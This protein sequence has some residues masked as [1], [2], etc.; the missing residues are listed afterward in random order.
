[1]V[2]LVLLLSIIA[3]AWIEPMTLSFNCNDECAKHVVVAVVEAVV[4]V[5]E[6]DC[7]RSTTNVRSLFFFFFDGAVS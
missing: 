3:N 4:S 2:L 5:V 1:M 7:S 6:E